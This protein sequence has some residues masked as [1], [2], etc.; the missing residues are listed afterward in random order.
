MGSLFFMFWIGDP[1]KEPNEIA[2][3]SKSE[4]IQDFLQLAKDQAVE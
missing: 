2:Y 4:K 1:T 3:M